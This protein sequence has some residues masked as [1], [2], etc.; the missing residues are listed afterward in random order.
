ML[1]VVHILLAPVRFMRDESCSTA[2]ATGLTLGMFLGFV[3][4]L[5]M[6]AMLV[7]TVVLFLRINV[8]AA[9][10]GYGVF[11]LAAAA[12]GGPLDALG[13]ALLRAEGLQ[14]LWSFFYNST[15]H[16]CLLHN[17]LALG[18]TLMATVLLAPVFLVSRLLIRAWRHRVESAV[19]QSR[20]ARTLRATWLY[21]AY[22]WGA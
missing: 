5:S 9:L 16:Y 12:L 20:L 13:A 22:R 11:G 4:L 17:S 15:F 8:L 21:R 19:A 6:Q 3:P 7:I 14:G 1:M 18:G 2:L 10:V